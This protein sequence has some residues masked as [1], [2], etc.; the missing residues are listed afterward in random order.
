LIRETDGLIERVE[1][2]NEALLA[3]ARQAA[4]ETIEA[5][6]AAVGTDLERVVSEAMTRETILQPLEWLRDS[7]V[8]QQSLAH[9]A[10]AESEAVRLK[11]H[12]LGAIGKYLDERAAAATPGTAPKLSIKQSRVIKPATLVK[13]GYLE[14][15]TDVGKFIETLRDAM[16]Q[17]LDNNERIE[18]R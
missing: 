11:D 2:V 7:V 16:E 9:L 18:I 14:T 8:K 4:R 13:G 10:Q 3:A 5:Q 6:R 12:A 15:R 1:K 17:A